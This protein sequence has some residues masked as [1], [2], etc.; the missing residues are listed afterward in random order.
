MLVPTRVN[1]QL[2]FSGGLSLNLRVGGR[3]HVTGDLQRT[4]RDER[5]VSYNS[6]GLPQ[7]E[8]NTGSDYW[9]GTLQF[10]WAL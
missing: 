6:K 5:S 3:G 2:N 7:S 10:S 9:N 1:R 4:Y 8:V